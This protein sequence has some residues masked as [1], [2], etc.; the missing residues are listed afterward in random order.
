MARD[1]L[2]GVKPHRP[3]F[4]P[5][6]FSL[7]ARVENLP[8]SAYLGN[9][10]KI[11]NSLRQIRGRLPSDGVTCYFDPYAEVE[12][13]GAALR[14][15]EDD[16]P[17][18]ICWPGPSRIGELP[19]DL[20]SPEDAVKSGRIPV[21]AE[22]IRRLNSLLRDDVLL[23]AGVSGPFSLA[24]RLLQSPLQEVPPAESLPPD[25]I[26]FA[27]SMLTRVSSAYLEAGAQVI[28]IHED[29]LPTL[30]SGSCDAWSGLLAP[31]FNLI[32]FY[33]AL[34][35]LLLTDAAAV[36]RD[37][38]VLLNRDWECILCPALDTSSLGLSSSKRAVQN[39]IALPLQVL[40]PDQGRDE[41]LGS[42][43]DSRPSVITTAGD[44]PASTDLKRL[45]ARFGE[46]R[47]SR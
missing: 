38:E 8:L 9:P 7:G 24:V 21:A 30:S 42:V 14:W 31:T 4:L 25:A 27:A 40:L 1:L 16:Q 41:W 37:Q 2:Q 39:G 15:H 34:S 29:I 3:L 5:V 43:L 28:L 44:L 32:R 23:M 13:L 47:A 36:T 19:S 35:V 33:G 26:E 12:A 6:I 45:L 10:T 18:S 46:V 11:C 22:V 17:P 20:R